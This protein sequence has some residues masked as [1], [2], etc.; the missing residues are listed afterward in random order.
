MAF[1]FPDINSNIVRGGILFRDVDVV[2]VR[3]QFF[4]IYLTKHPNGGVRLFKYR[5]ESRSMSILFLLFF[6]SFFFLFAAMYKFVLFL[7]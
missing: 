3:R 4:G 1:G 7:L 5:F 6:I 2:D